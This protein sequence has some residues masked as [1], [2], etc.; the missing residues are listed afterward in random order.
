MAKKQQPAPTGTE[1]VHHEEV[2]GVPAKVNQ[3]VPGIALLSDDMASEIEGVEGAGRSDSAEDR[4]TP[5]MYIAQKMSPQ[6]ERKDAAFIDGLEVGN[7][8]NNITREFYDAEGDGVEV[9]P[10]FYRM[11]WNEWTPRDEGGG[12][13]GSHPRDTPLLKN[14]KPFV[15]PK[16]GK[17]RRDIFI[18][19]NGHQLK[20]TA[21]YFCILV[22][23]WRPII[24]PMAS[25]NLGAARTLQGMIDAQLV[26]VGSRIVNK[27]AFWTRFLLKT[28]YEEF[29]EGTAYKYVISSLGEN[30]NK[31]LREHCKSFALSCLKNEV[32]MAAPVD[33]TSAN[34]GDDIPV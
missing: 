10:C 15:H 19:D 24:I 18:M 26:Q 5:L 33:E 27:P 13:H 7:V 20:L 22:Q 9:L 32:K 14:A 31:A 11:N 16:T 6:V 34:S 25:T 3:I 4:G 12:F 21:H 23:T 1:V 17:V 30:Q 28:A 2:G 8:F 29:D